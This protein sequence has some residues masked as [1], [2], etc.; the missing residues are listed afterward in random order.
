MHLVEEY[1]QIAF[2]LS[3]YICLWSSN[4]LVILLWNGC[5]QKLL[6]L[7]S[8][9]TLARDHAENVFVWK[10]Y[11]TIAETITNE[12][13]RPDRSKIA[14]EKKILADFVRP[15]I[16]NFVKPCA[17]HTKCKS[18]RRG[19]QIENGPKRLCLHAFH[20]QIAGK[21]LLHKQMSRFSRSNPKPERRD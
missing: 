10:C 20:K 15:A 14:A 11:C 6:G 17:H 1:P 12:A 5:K 21:L 13:I 16:S 4:L 8:S 7:V 19:L 18:S 3:L 9:C 2:I